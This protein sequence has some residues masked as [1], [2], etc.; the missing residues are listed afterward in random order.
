MAT[1]VPYFK[2]QAPIEATGTVASDFGSSGL[3]ADVIEESTSGNGVS[4]DGVVLQD[5]GVSASLSLADGDLLSIFGNGTGTGDVVLRVGG[6]ATE[7]LELRVYEATVSPSAIETNLINMPATSR[8]ISVQSNVEAALTGGGTTD[9]YGI[10]TAG[11]PDKYGSSATLTQNSKTDFLGD[12]TVLASTEQMVLTGTAS[13]T[14]D[15]DTAL[16]VGSV[17]VRV[18][19]ETLNSLDDAS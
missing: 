18:V 16:T 4:V 8:I 3:K 19:Y 11:D 2:V 10:G 15:G 14:A 13:E 12:A 17:R 9:S 5:G 7:G 6:S 1:S